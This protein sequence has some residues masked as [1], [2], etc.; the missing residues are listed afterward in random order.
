MDDFKKGEK[1][2]KL[3]CK[4]NEHFFHDEGENCTGIKKWLSKQNTCPICRT[5]FPMENNTN[6]TNNTD[7][8]DNIY[9][10]DNGIRQLMGNILMNSIRVLN[11]QEIIE[12]EEQRQLE[13]AIQ[14]S[15]E[16]Q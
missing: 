9:E 6:N 3:P 10:I 2:L 16:E 11:P 7:N 12:N 1:C 14:A 4:E 8:T 5:E 15:L 13:E